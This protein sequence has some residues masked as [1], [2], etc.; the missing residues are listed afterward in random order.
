MPGLTP[1]QVAP[2][3]AAFSAHEWMLADLIVTADPQRAISSCYVGRGPS[4]YV[5]YSK[6]GIHYGTSV[7]GPHDVIRWTA[8][9]TTIRALP[10]TTRQ[11][12]ADAAERCRDSQRNFRIFAAPAHACGGGRPP[13]VGPLTARQQAYEDALEDYE[14][15]VRQP[16][17]A[18][19]EEVKAAR[20]AAIEACFEDTTDDLLS[21]AA[22]LFD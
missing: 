2:L 22:T 21:Y 1:D 15:N 10:S 8:V 19:D 12:V 16:W 4:R 9:L 5:T 14:T 13:Q 20:H 18:N 11:A 3:L 17:Q 7:C 6:I